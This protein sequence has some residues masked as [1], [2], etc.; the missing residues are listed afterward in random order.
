MHFS[1]FQRS[2]RTTIIIYKIY[3]V[4]K[5]TFLD[6][7]IISHIRLNIH[8]VGKVPWLATVIIHEKSS[9]FV[10]GDS[11]TVSDFNGVI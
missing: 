5:E 4:N 11:C 8:P 9:A 7:Q 6:F 10:Y 1:Y 3:F 2:S